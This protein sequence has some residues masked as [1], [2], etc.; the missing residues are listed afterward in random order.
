MEEDKLDW[1]LFD[2]EQCWEDL[3]D[4]WTDWELRAQPANQAESLTGRPYCEAN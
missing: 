3:H 4:L 1:W 2:M